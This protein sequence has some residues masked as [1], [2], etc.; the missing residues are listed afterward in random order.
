MHHIHI[1]ALGPRM[2]GTEVALVTTL[3][4]PTT[5]RS[6]TGELS[7]GWIDNTILGAPGTGQVL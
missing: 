7:V 6:T 2:F 5:V 3:D 1:D 4:E